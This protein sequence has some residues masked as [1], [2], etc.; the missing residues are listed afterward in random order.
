MKPKKSFLDSDVRKLIVIV[1]V[2]KKL[3]LESYYN[4]VTILRD[5]IFKKNRYSRGLSVS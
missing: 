4:F 1:L 3:V 5:C 2:K